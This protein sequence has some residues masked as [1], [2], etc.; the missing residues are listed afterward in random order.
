LAAGIWQSAATDYY[1]SV[2]AYQLDIEVTRGELVESRHRVHA[3]VVDASGALVGSARDASLVTH[4]R[5]CA[6][7]FQVM[8][9]VES[10]GFDEL[11]WN[12]EMLALACGSHGGEPEHVV[13]A[14]EMLRELG[15]EEGDLACG[16]HEPLSARGSKLLRESGSR[17]T[18][19]HNN[20]S[21]K[22]AAMMARAHTADWNP[23]GYERAGHQVQ[24]SILA[25]VASWT[26]VPE[27]RMGLA[28][29]GCGVVEFSLPLE[30]MA[31]AY[32]RLGDA[33]RRGEETAARITGA[34]TAQPFYVGGTDRFDTI[35]LEETAGRVVPKLGAEGVHCAAV[36]G[37]GIGVAVKVEDGAQRAQH[38][39]LLR[40]LQ[41]VGAL[42][43]TLPPRL[44]KI[45][46]APVS[47][48]RRET[49]GIVRPVA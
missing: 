37:L 12:D 25:K 31:Y 11:G 19:L 48:T 35:L 29:D 13:V 45:L 49:V 43:E 23:H 9:F 32:A 2:S 22:H 3:A 38:P 36:P 1:P 47:N 15:L 39:A 30:R 10:G 42:P 5:S 21:G 26:G 40:V 8:P 34:M 41:L 44:A 46:H 33:S 4:W 24:Q 18:R 17:P 28:V 7:P 14:A 6:K 20:C 27:S 16:P